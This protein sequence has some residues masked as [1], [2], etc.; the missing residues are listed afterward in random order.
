MGDT[1]KRFGYKEVAVS[2]T[3]FQ[4]FNFHE[5]CKSGPWT[6]RQSLIQ[7]IREEAEIKQMQLKSVDK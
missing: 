5:K 6:I 3:R 7:W 2:C 1:A 4:D